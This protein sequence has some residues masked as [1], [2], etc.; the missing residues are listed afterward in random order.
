[1]SLPGK[2]RHEWM[3]RSN[4]GVRQKVVRVHADGPRIKAYLSAFGAKMAMAS[5]R[6]H[7][8][9]ALPLDGA[10]WCQFALNGGVTQE[11]LDARVKVLPIHETLQQGRKHVGDQFIYRYNCDERSVIAAVLQFHRGLWFTAFASSDQGIIELFRKP[12]FLQ[13]PA[14]AM[15]RPGN[16]LSLLPAPAVR[17]PDGK[18]RDD[19]LNSE[20]T[21]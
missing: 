14:S 16:L 15:I 6:E 5:Y 20:T 13:L 7:I 18:S 19:D 2:F 3:R 9:I 10:I 1:M 8:G 21:R 4:S 12:E 11:D 17:R